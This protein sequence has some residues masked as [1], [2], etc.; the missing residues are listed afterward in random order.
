MKKH[1]DTKSVDELRNKIIGLGDKSARKSYYPQLQA[2]INELEIAKKKAEESENRF[3]ILLNSTS[4]GIFIYY[5]ENGKL[6]LANET[7]CRMTG[8]CHGDIENLSISDIHPLTYREKILKDFEIMKN[9]ELRLLRNVPVKK[10]D[11]T[12]IYCEINA[13]SLKMDDQDFIILAYRDVTE[14]RESELRQREIEKKLNEAQKLESIGIMAGGVAHDFNNILSVIM[15]LTEI[16]LQQNSRDEKISPKLKKI[17]EASTRARDLIKQL[18]TISYH[19]NDEKKPSHLIS[20]INESVAMMRATTPSSIKIINENPLCHDLVMADETQINQILINLFN[21]SVYAMPDR[22]GEIKIAYS[23][24]YIDESSL[25]Y[26]PLLM[27]GQYFTIEFSDNGTGIK[28]EII[29]RV[30]D[31]FY[32]TKPKGE[33]TGLGLSIIHGIIK[34]HDG[35]ISVE[36]EAGKGTK[37]IIHLPIYEGEYMETKS[38]S[39]QINK[40]QGRIMVVDDE[41][42]LAEVNGE[43][44]KLLDY[45]VTVITSSTD[46]LNAFKEKP[47]NF[48]LIITDMTMPELNGLDL[49]REILGIRPEIPVILCTGFSDQITKE[50]AMTVGVREFLNKPVTLKNLA[51]TVEHILS[52]E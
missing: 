48:D 42:T 4:D 14:I 39:T 36:S 37:F 1:S 30:F 34:K 50:S 45:D 28:Q 18:M 44:L 47:E 41:E 32:T 40:G 52:S 11:G 26:Y 13:S 23:N 21:N 20:V 9:G 2:R 7:A 43:M 51:A 35:N 15:G 19:G 22:K 31:P 3:K 12:I 10:H 8:Y 6:Y 16:L 46:A 24:E 33:G 49:A 27:K 25:K 29:D 38:D 17:F 5:S